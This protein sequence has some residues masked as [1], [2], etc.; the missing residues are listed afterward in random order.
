MAEVT[1]TS[2]TNHFVSYHIVACVSMDGHCRIVRWFIKARPSGTGIKFRIGSKKF[3]MTART[4]VCSLVVVVP[5]FARKS[6]LGP[7]FAKH[8]ILNRRQFFFPFFIGFS[9]RL[10]F[11]SVILFGFLH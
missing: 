7:F 1:T 5:V 10:L 4:V 11:H 9:Q 6:T 8:V 3:M 2:A